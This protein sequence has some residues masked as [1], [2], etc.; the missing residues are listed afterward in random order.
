MHA[1][2]KNSYNV[3]LVKPAVILLVERNIVSFIFEQFT[4]LPLFSLVSKHESYHWKMIDF[5]EFFCRCVGSPLISGTFSLIL[6]LLPSL[7]LHCFHDHK[8]NL[9]ILIKDFHYVQTPEY[10]ESG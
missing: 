3:C 5:R 7:S 1:S 8:Q 2:K 10:I 9:C 6:S 4:V